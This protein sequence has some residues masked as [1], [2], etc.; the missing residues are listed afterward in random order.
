[1]KEKTHVIQHHMYALLYHFLGD[2]RACTYCR[3]I[4]LNYAY[5]AES[6]SIGEDLNVLSDSSCSMCVLEPSEPRTPVGGRKASRNIFLEEDL[7]WQRWYHC[8]VL[9]LQARPADCFLIT[10]YVWKLMGGDRSASTSTNAVRVVLG[11]QSE[12]PSSPHID[13]TER[14]PVAFKACAFNCSKVFSLLV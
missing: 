5:S 1:M 4:A 14:I 8:E 3:K 10:G 6:G 9:S 13:G 12:F 2:L 7:T 11:R